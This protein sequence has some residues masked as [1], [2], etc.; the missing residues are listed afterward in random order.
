MEPSNQPPKTAPNANESA[1]CIHPQI[2]ISASAPNSLPIETTGK[3]DP[4]KA[5]YAP[6]GYQGFL[7]GM[8]QPYL[9]IQPAIP[10]NPTVMGYAYAPRPPFMP[11]YYQTATQTMLSPYTNS[12]CTQ[13]N[14]YTGYGNQ[15]YIQSTATPGNENQAFTQQP[16]MPQFD[17]WISQQEEPNDLANIEEETPIRRRKRRNRFR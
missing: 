14:I 13:P 4:V 11:P 2:S 7:Y 9:H 5:N 6:F 10:C 12:I 3:N 16:V 17:T 8:G 15:G 1:N